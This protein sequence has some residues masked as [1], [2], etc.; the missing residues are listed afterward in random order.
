MQSCRYV[1]D[2]TCDNE[3]F[4]IYFDQNARKL[5][6][7]RSQRVIAHLET[8]EQD[9]LN[10][11]S[12]LFFKWL[13]MHHLSSCNCFYAQNLLEFFHSKGLL[14][15]K[16]TVDNPV[17]QLKGRYLVVFSMGKGDKQHTFAKI[18]NSI[19]ELKV[20]T[21]KKP[22]EIKRKV[23]QGKTDLSCSSL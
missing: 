3:K 20:D 7:Q 13:V 6:G 2:P 10:E 23:L 1:Y 8:L 15:G 22:S 21:G 11:E 12:V 17:K 18:Y 9:D 14:K 16:K 4:V 19:R 5:Q